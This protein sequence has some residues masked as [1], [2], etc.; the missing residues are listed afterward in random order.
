MKKL[1]I[2]GA[3]LLSVFALL[4][5]SC[6]KEED[7]AAPEENNPSEE[8]VTP[9][10]EKVVISAGIPEEMTKVG[11][12]DNGVGSGMA[13]AWQAEDK[14]RVIATGGGSGNEQFTIKSGFTAHSAEFEGT[15]VEGTEYTVFYPGTYASVDAINVRNYTDQTQIGNGSTAHLEWNAIETGLADYSTVDFTTKQ[16]GALRVK[17]TLPD[18]FTKVYQVQIVATDG[19]DPANVFSTTNAGGSKTNTLTLNLKADESTPGITLG[20]DKVLTSYIMVS[21]ND[22]VLPEGTTLTFKV[23]GDQEDPWTKVKTIGTG[24]FTIYGG[25]VTNISLN[26]SNWEEPLFWG[27]DGTSEHPYLIKTLANLNNM[28]YAAMNSKGLIP[29][30][31]ALVYFKLID[32]INVGTWSMVNT[33]SGNSYKFYFDGNNHTL[34]N[35]S[36][37]TPG[38][39]FF[40]YMDG[41]T[42]K[43]LVFNTVTLSNDVES[44]SKNGAATVS[45][46]A[47]NSTIDNVDVNDVTITVTL[48]DDYNNQGTGAVAGRI[49]DNSTVQNCDVTGLTI[50]G[51]LPATRFGGI[52]GLTSGSGTR[53]ISNCTV[54]N[55]TVSASASKYVGGIVGRNSAGTG[56]TI[57]N[58]SVTQGSSPWAGINGSDFVGGIIGEGGGAVIIDNCD[59]VGNVTSSTSANG[60]GGIAG[61]V[62]A[63][64]VIRNDCSFNGNVSGKQNTGGILGG[65]NNKTNITIS[66]ATVSGSITGTDVRTGGIVGALINAASTG[67]TVTGCR[68]VNGTTI[69][70]T[71]MVG[72][73]IGRLEAVATISSNVI[74]ADITGTKYIGGIGGICNGGTFTS[75]KVAGYIHRTGSESEA[76][77]GGLV[78]YAQNTLAHRY[79]KN[80]VTARIEGSKFTGGLIGYTQN[81]ETGFLIEECAYEGPEVAGGYSL[82]GEYRVGGLVGGIGGSSP[83]NITIRNCYSSGSLSCTGWSGGLFGFFSST[84]STLLIEN[85]YS[86]MDV[87]STGNVLGGIIGGIGTENASNWA[88][89]DS[90]VTVQ[91]CVSWGSVDYGMGSGNY[92]YGAVLGGGSRKSTMTDNYRKYGMTI[93]NTVG[94]KSVTNDP[95]TSSTSPNTKNSHDGVEAGSSDTVSSVASTL[96]WSTTIWDL[97]GTYPTLKNLPE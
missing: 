79:Q 76:C 47:L 30:G 92:N 59:V 36:S 95:N 55:M 35:F 43:N 15:S 72:G 44:T 78:G 4:L 41:C 70:G 93:K 66:N 77:V 8:I 57:Q 26:N 50:T 73:V 6:S 82:T 16:N 25:K 49:G 61:V 54:T 96:D 74:D 2:N 67:F 89:E 24:G 37:T 63:N 33:S 53:A 84:T 97:N 10:P 52:V 62:N 5:V 39:S 9:A 14:L 27:G 91:K 83:L 32:D 18:A 21:W 22:D 81:T 65:V 17:L 85:S 31:D 51:S 71:T 12:T 13:L 42:V 45:Y 3:A 87:K 19:D 34:S 90:A 69:T 28:H 48:G 40:G 11:F 94:N 64:S 56:T 29:A 80:L 38:A 23:T 86:T 68:V 75:N 1:F 7:K 58:C 20:V 46:Y 60:I 88:T